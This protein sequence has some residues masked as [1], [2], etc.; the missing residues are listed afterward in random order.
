LFVQSDGVQKEQLFTSLHFEISSTTQTL[1]F[2]IGNFVGLYTYT[3][4]TL[5][6]SAM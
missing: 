2:A 1:Q 6:A 3:Q 5:M 4:K